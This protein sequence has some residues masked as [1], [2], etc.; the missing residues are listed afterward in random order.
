MVVNRT[1]PDYRHLKADPDLKVDPEPEAAA[2][3]VPP[4][5]RV[6][7]PVRDR[8]PAP[9]PRQGLDPGPAPNHVPA[10]GFVS[11]PVPGLTRE[12][13]TEPTQARAPR[14]GQATGT[15]QGRSK[16]N[17]SSAA[18][19][20]S[21]DGEQPMQCD[22][23][24]EHARDAEVSPL[25]KE[26]AA[27][28]LMVSK[29]AKEMAEIERVLSEMHSSTEREVTNTP[30]P[31]PAGDGSMAIKRRAVTRAPNLRQTVPKGDAASVRVVRSTPGKQ[32]RNARVAVASVSTVH[33]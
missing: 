28:K 6:E 20:G 8:G 18:R 4:P 30:V 15:P 26:N 32:R 21:I 22:P 25:R 11:G 7:S 24:P 19:T 13:L 9:G 33:D 29:M 3:A 5:G 12:R 10:P 1:S 16:S 27:L 31:A 14:P 23:P 2:G 17:L